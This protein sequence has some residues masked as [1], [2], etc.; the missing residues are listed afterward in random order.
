MAAGAWLDS[1][2]FMENVILAARA[3]GLETC[4]QQ[5]WCDFG[6]VVHHELSILDDYMLLSGMAIGH[7]DR[8][9][10]ENTIFSNRVPVEEFTQWHS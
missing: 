5:S 7:E 8:S 2:M 10:P 1:G 3:H 6:A 9:A 4:L